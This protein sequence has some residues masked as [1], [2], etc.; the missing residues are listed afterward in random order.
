MLEGRA[1]VKGRHWP[2][3]EEPKSY[4]VK[5]ENKNIRPRL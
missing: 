3:G 1:Y 2:I 4:F 5:D